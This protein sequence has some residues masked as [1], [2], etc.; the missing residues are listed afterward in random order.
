M[1]YTPKQLTHS[2][3]AKLSVPILVV[4][5]LALLGFTLTAQIQ[6]TRMVETQVK[7]R[8]LE[9]AESFA[10][11]T[12]INSLPANFVR[13]VNSIG[14]H[15]DVIGVFL[16]DDRTRQIIAASKNRYIDDSIEGLDDPALQKLLSDALQ[17][18]GSEQAFKRNERYHFAYKVQAIAED[19]KSLR[20]LTLSVEL[21]ISAIE[22]YVRQINSQFY[23]TL[24][25]LLAFLALASYFLIRTIV[26][27][28]VYQLVGAI[29]H[30]QSSGT[31]V[32][33]AYQSSD[34]MGVLTGAYN[35]MI[36]DNFRKQ[37]QLAEERQKS[38]EA[39]QA[40][41][42][43][44]AM[45]THELRTPLNGVIGMSQ[46]L[47]ELI[48]DEQKREYLNIIQLS[49]GQ[50]L[51]VINDTL[52]FSKIEADRLELDIQPFSLN[53]VLD[54]LVAMFKQQLTD[55]PVELVAR[56]PDTPLPKL[57]GDS[58]RVNQ[59]VLNLL[60]NAVKF[61]EQGEVTLELKVDEAGQGR[62]SFTLIVADTGIG[63]SDKQQQG[64]FS[65]FTQAESSTT[66]KYGGTGL[67]L[68]ICRKLVE[69]MGGSIDV[70]SVEGEG[71]QFVISLSMMTAREEQPEPKAI[72]SDNVSNT[73]VRPLRVLLVEDIEINRMVVMAMLNHDLV[74]LDV[75]TNGEEAV[76]A[77]R[78]ANY[79]V[80]LMDCLMPVM[81]GFEAS[82]QIRGLEQAGD[83][84]LTTPIIALT[85]N[86]ME[87]TRQQCLQAGMNDF[88]TKPVVAADLVKLILHWS[89]RHNAVELPE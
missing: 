13:V 11:A 41:S 89:G 54:N 9:L 20:A 51:A 59:V 45:M 71:A 83:S 10:V 42:R 74:T 66:R 68:W 8:A 38:E 69:K 80:I 64:L 4:F 58:T 87:E 67:G 33:S 16:V 1:D 34:E 5:V 21:D 18:G 79:D 63:L 76:S 25:S 77:F 49:A 29:K 57:M 23:I 56:L 22:A 40:K 39:L 24:V 88:L 70:N 75:A 35:E 15:S 48:V 47:D 44:L 72:P 6:S 3:N 46:R 60:S 43:F 86:A 31:P 73:F 50:L 2:V 14:A 55:K 26:L 27:K 19:E 84:E 7:Q 17:Y 81:D 52:D 78:Q 53:Q 65:E 62:M 28:P 30:T 36:E 12:E 61:T 37:H 82:R 85:A 32:Q